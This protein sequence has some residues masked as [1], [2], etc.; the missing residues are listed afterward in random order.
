MCSSSCRRRPVPKARRCRRP[1]RNPSSASSA[2]LTLMFA[3]SDCDR[4]VLAEIAVA[5][6]AVEDLVRRDRVAVGIRDARTARPPTRSPCRAPDVLSAAETT[7]AV[8]AGGNT[9]KLFHVLQLGAVIDLHPE[10]VAAGAQN[11][12]RR[13]ASSSGADVDIHQLSLVDAV[14]AEMAAADWCRRR[15]CTR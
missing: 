13:R 2:A 15:T 4:A 12:L 3:S 7:G 14:L 5:G 6:R 10:H 11:E 8:F 9:V 1:A